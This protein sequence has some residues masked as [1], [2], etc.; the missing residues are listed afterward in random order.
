LAIDQP[1]YQDSG[2]L[3]L[4]VDFG[5]DDVDVDDG[6]G[7]K[8]V[9]IDPQ[10]VQDRGGPEKPP[11]EVHVGAVVED[12]RDA[13]A[14]GDAVALAEVKRLVDDVVDDLAAPLSLLLLGPVALQLD[15]V[16]E[17][18]VGH[19]ELSDFHVLEIFQFVPAKKTIH[20]KVN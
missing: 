10:L 12:K 2:V 4:P 7:W 6:V 9:V 11:P 13:T 17:G 20:L 5:G 1:I 18:D 15:P 8:V 19:V 16:V 14:G 3:S